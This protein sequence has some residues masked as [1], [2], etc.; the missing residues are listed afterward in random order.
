MVNAW[1]MLPAIAYQSGTVIAGDVAAAHNMLRGTIPGTTPQYL[2]DL[3]RGRVDPLYPRLAVQLPV[4][5]AAWIVAGLLIARPSAAL[6][7]SGR[8][9]SCSRWQWRPGR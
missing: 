2:F 6:P 9:C 4:L 1:Y 5:A 3:G 8:R 7:G